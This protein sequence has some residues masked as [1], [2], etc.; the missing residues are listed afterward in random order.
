[1]REA[2]LQPAVMIDCS[3]ANAGG[4]YRRQETVWHNV[5]EQVIHGPTPIV[6][7]MVES[8]LEEGKQPFL[9]DRSK[10]RYGVSVTDGCVGWATTE[11]MLHEAHLAL[12]RAR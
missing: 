2:S 11:L 10:L 9:A 7:M 5:V 1:M 3:H 12:E 6:G 8:N 4:D